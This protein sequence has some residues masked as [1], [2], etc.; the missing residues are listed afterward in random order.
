MKR[1]IPFF[2]ALLLTAC[3]AGQGA[4]AGASPAAAPP[5]VDAPAASSAETP[6]AET[7]TPAPPGLTYVDP[8][9]DGKVMPLGSYEEATQY[10]MPGNAAA[11]QNGYALAAGLWDGDP[12]AVR[13][14]CADSVLGEDF[15]LNDLTGL[16]VTRA[17]LG[18]GRYEAPYLS[19]YVTDPGAT[20]LRMG[21]NNLYLGFDGEEK[22]CAV[23][24]WVGVASQGGGETGSWISLGAA[25]W[26]NQG[27][28]AEYIRV[29]GRQADSLGLAVDETRSTRIRQPYSEE[30]AS[31]AVVIGPGPT[32]PIPRGQ[33]LFAIPPEGNVLDEENRQLVCDDLNAILREVREGTY[34]SIL[35]WWDPAY[36]LPLKVRPQDLRTV[37]RDWPGEEAKRLEIWVPLPDHR[38]AYWSCRQNAWRQGLDAGPLFRAAPL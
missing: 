15:P 26:Q 28:Y 29:E 30:G 6:P 9:L 5:A 19:L 4:S 33:E 12:E 24:P 23:S 10:F 34:D 1:W 22:I 21:W 3:G 32:W 7:P 8:P 38:W 25:D 11:R 20:P 2:L 13:A 35:P 16:T 37:L 31:E 14:A 27:D 18:G 36:P 17:E